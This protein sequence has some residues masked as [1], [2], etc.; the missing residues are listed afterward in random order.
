MDD[1]IKL[2][3]ISA[4]GQRAECL[5]SEA[6]VDLAIEKMSERISTQL[7][8]ANPV[9]L[10]VMTGAL[11]LTA[12][13]SMKLQFPLNIDYVHATR[14]RNMTRGSELQWIKEP[15]LDLRGRAVLIVDDIFDEG[16]TLEGV[17]AYCK[18]NGADEV[19]TA[20]MVDKVHNRKVT[21]LTCDFVGLKTQDR[22]LYGSGMDYKGYFRNAAGIYAI[23]ESDL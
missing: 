22:Y 2:A 20:V 13:L 4:V 17:V 8:A 7:S 3:E 23:A 10:C 15:S 16:I 14:Y 19:F 5:Y 9:M 12:R 11:F 6:E 1:H 21:N 18:G